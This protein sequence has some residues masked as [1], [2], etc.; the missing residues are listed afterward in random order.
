MCVCGGGGGGEGRG[1]DSVLIFKAIKV[2]SVLF[3]SFECIS[4]SCLAFFC[5]LLVNK[6]IH[7]CLILSA[8]LKKL[9]VDFVWF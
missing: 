3:R 1:V 7:G 2:T 6:E 8:A 4:L 5:F 9:C